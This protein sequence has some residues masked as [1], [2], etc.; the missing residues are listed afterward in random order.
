DLKN[1]NVES[2]QLGSVAN[3]DRFSVVGGTATGTL[4]TTNPVTAGDALA[5]ADGVSWG[6]V[7]ANNTATSLTWEEGGAPA[8]GFTL[9]KDAGDNLYASKGGNLYNVTLA[10]TMGTQ[11]DGNDTV[12]KVTVGAQV[13][14]TGG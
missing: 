10:G 1:M 11:N 6:T 13:T 8:S 5:A 9:V 4:P 14:P 2:L 12:L 7:G 3:G